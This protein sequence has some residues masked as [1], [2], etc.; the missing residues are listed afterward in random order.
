MRE[1][2]ACGLGNARR[3]GVPTVAARA[4]RE[5]SGDEARDREARGNERV[6]KMALRPRAAA[7]GRERAFDTR[8]ENAARVQRQ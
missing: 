4:A 2:L 1:A 7:R 3:T 5:P 6:W 8:G